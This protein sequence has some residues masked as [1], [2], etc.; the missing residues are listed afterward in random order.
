M[1]RIKQCF[2][3]TPALGHS[4][5]LF[6]ILAARRFGS[7]T[8][9]GQCARCMNP[10]PLSHSVQTLLMF[11]TPEKR[12]NGGFIQRL[13]DPCSFFPA[14]EALQQGAKR[15]KVDSDVD[16]VFSQS[17]GAAHAENSVP[18]RPG[19]PASPPTTFVSTPSSYTS[20]TTPSS[21]TSNLSLS[22]LSSISSN[23]STSS[24]GPSS[25]PLAIYSVNRNLAHVPNKQT[26]LSLKFGDMKKEFKHPNSKLLQVLQQALDRLSTGCAFCWSLDNPSPA[27]HSYHHCPIVNHPSSNFISAHE[28]FR[29]GI[30][31]PQH[32]ACYGCY[33]PKVSA[34]VARF[35][36]ALMLL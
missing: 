9:A 35:A 34:A 4:L 19:A 1:F 11:K 26:L 15:Q 23:S 24:N 21:S 2:L 10:S 17:T 7:G 28:S 13:P 8:G 25:S 20:L 6:P 5:G 31:V 32:M 12:P 27:A 30:S 33:V 18:P 22:N 36:I 29:C 3:L 14:D 16:D